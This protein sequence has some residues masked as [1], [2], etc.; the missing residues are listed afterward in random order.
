MLPDAVAKLVREAGGAALL[1]DARRG[2]ALLTDASQLEI[3]CKK[4]RNAG[5]VR[6]IDF[7]AEHVGAVKDGGQEFALLLTLRHPGHAHCALTLKWKWLESASRGEAMLRPSGA[8]EDEERAKHGFAPTEEGP[9][10]ETLAPPAKPEAQPDFRPIS[11]AAAREL[12]QDTGRMPAPSDVADN[13]SR[14]AGQPGGQP[15]QASPVAHPSLSQIWP[16]AAL[17]ER[18]IFEM[19]GI[20]FSGHADLCP[21]LLD[22]QFTGFPLRRDFVPPS[23]ESFAARL[24]RDRHEAAMIDA[25]GGRPSLAANESRAETPALL[26][27]PAGTRALQEDS[28]GG[29]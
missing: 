10:A 22:E 26:E 28:G 17:A 14:G 8:A 3:I 5:F 6:L 15:L 18:E 29:A 2:R 4:L 20:P 27:S 23:R 11:E 24:L 12:A 7:T 21:L 19:F 13:A 1:L 9:Q 16:A 25:L